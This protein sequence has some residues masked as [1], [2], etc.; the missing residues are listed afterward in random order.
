MKRPPVQ[1]R[2]HAYTGCRFFLGIHLADEEIRKLRFKKENVSP[3][4][5]P[6]RLCGVDDEQSR[7]HALRKSELAAQ[8]RS[9]HLQL[10]RM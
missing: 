8:D 4:V 10:K 5:A 6:H 7:T 2:S 9:F 1:T 3:R